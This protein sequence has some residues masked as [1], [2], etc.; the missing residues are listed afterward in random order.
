MVYD[1]EIVK[2]TKPQKSKKLRLKDF[3]NSLSLPDSVAVVEKELKNL[4][5]KDVAHLEL[6]KEGDLD[7]SKLTLIA[8]KILWNAISKQFDSHSTT[9][10]EIQ[11]SSTNL[12]TLEGVQVRST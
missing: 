3:L 5:V 1:L 8:K 10:H 12:V 2:Q 9:N 11:K 6:L 7:N 4:G